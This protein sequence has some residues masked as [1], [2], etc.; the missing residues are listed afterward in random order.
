[1]NEATR[2]GLIERLSALLLREPED[3][4]QLLQLLRSAYQRNLLDAELH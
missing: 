2:P 1:M 3:R 4:E